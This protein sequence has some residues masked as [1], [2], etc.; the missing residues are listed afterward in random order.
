MAGQPLK[1]AAPNPAPPTV[2]KVRLRFANEMI[3]G[4]WNNKHVAS[5]QIDV[6]ERLGITDRAV[7]YDATG[8]PQKSIL[9]SNN[10]PQSKQVSGYPIFKV[11]FFL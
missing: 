2:A 11:F 3:G 7:F 4:I 9:G 1:G 6:P 8:D 10:N 5:V